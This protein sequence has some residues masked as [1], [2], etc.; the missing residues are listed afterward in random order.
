MLYVARSVFV[1]W[2]SDKELTE[3][4]HV[5]QWYLTHRGR[6]THIWVGNLNIIGSD[7][8]LS[9]DRRQAII[10]TNAGIINLTFGNKL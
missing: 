9:P 4:T 2:C 8:G 10:S 5:F 7:N 1:V 6:V 3:F